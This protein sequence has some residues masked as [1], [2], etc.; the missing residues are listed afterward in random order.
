M[1]RVAISLSAIAMLTTACGDDS[2]AGGGA[3]T[4][5]FCDLAIAQSP[6]D[7]DTDTE[8]VDLDPFVAAAPG[9][10]RSDL[11]RVQDLFAE[12][13]QISGRDGDE[14]AFVAALAA[15]ADPVLTAAFD[16]IEQTLV[17]DCGELA[18]GLPSSAASRLICRY[19]WRGITRSSA[20][21][22]FVD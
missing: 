8:A 14:A 7:G 10:L 11:E 18:S 20:P 9:S 17:D 16:N 2:T 4:E 5:A 19:G 6:F 21:Q 12:I 3:S 1:Q 22:C 13:E 15:G